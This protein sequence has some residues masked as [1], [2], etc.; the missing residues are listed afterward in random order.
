MD[1]LTTFLYILLRDH[2]PAGDVEDILQHHAEV[3]GSPVYSNPHLA[4]YAKEL[5]QR[6]VSNFPA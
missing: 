1:R 4:A 5:A 2:V 3:P 6:L